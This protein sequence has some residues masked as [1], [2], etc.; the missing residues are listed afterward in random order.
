MVSGQ[1]RTTWLVAILV[2]VLT[3][4]IVGITAYFTIGVQRQIGRTDAEAAGLAREIRLERFFGAASAWAASA[5]CR[6]LDD[7]TT[8]AL[9]NAVDT[10]AATTD[11]PSI[12]AAWSAARN[13]GSVDAL[14]AA[15]YSSFMAISDDSGLTFDPAVAGIDVSDSLAYRIPAAADRLQRASRSLCE[16]HGSLGMSQRIEL[17]KNLTRAEQSMEDNSS[18]IADALAR[19]PSSASGA[20]A[21]AL[22]AVE[23]D[24]VPASNSVERLVTNPSSVTSPVARQSLD[25]LTSALYRLW[26][27]ETPLLANMLA[28]RLNDYGRERVVAVFPGIV[29]ILVAILVAYLA[30]RL[31]YERAAL[32]VAEKNAEEHKHVAMHD[33]LTGLLNRRA[34]MGVLQRAV[35]GSLYGAL[36]IFDVDDF[37][38]VNDTYGHLCG[39]ALLVNIARIL[40]SSVRSTDAVARLGGDEFAVFLHSPVD[41]AG[42]ER[43]LQAVALQ[44]ACA[45]VVRERTIVASVSAGAAMME[46]SGL[47]VEDAYAAADAAL[48]RAKSSSRGAFAF[49]EISAVT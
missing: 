25:R 49:G 33:D 32:E 21:A 40:E 20:T 47:S 2:A 10:A 13:S 44:V 19:D 46:R 3:L 16:T 39:D 7:P 38:G 12:P 45:L 17:V 34:F 9:R 29:G 28:R 31:I 24:A 22:R 23:Y 42:V 26:D 8:V 41:R 4:P 6:G 35:E 11:A 43:V 30:M 36:C 5:R 1:S 14:F 15:L 37:K 18:D 48:Y 27:S